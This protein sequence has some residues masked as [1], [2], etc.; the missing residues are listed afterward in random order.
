MG[1]EMER[2]MAR[3]G[4]EW[5]GV[6]EENDEGNMIKKMEE[7][8]ITDIEQ[9]IQKDWVK[10]D[11]STYCP[12]YGHLKTVISGEEYLYGETKNENKK[13]LWAGTRQ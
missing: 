8:L 3:L 1:K 13:K 6:V 7:L 10:I 4:R 12:Y 11:N 5:R 9:T 2:R